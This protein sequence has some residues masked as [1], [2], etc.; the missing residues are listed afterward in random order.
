MQLFL[1]LIALVYVAALTLFLAL[2][3]RAVRRSEPRPISLLPRRNNVI[4]FRPRRSRREESPARDAES[5][6]NVR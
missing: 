3:R 1:R 6:N 4:P 2:Y 5:V